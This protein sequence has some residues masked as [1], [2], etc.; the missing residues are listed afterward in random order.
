MR[1]KEIIKIVTT[2][3][4]S[5]KRP[6]LDQSTDFPVAPTEDIPT[7]LFPTNSNKQE[8]DK[9]LREIV[10]SI[11]HHTEYRQVAGLILPDTSI[12][13]PQTVVCSANVPEKVVQFLTNNSFSIKRLK[14]IIEKGVCI[15]IEELGFASYYPNTHHRYLKELSNIFQIFEINTLKEL[16]SESCWQEGDGLVTPIMN[17]KGQLFGLILLGCP[18]NC[19]V[20]SINAILP[21]LAFASQLAQAVEHRRNDATLFKINC[22]LNREK[23]K[24]KTLFDISAQ[25]KEASKLDQKLELMLKGISDIGWQRASIYLYDEL[26]GLERTLHNENALRHGG[27]LSD[28]MTAERRSEIF[29]ILSD[30]WKVEQCYYLRYLDTEAQPIIE[31]F[32]EGTWLMTSSAEAKEPNR[33]HPY[34][35]LL[36]PLRARGGRLI[37]LIHV[38]DPVDGRRPSIED[39][40]ILQLYGHESALM[41]EQASLYEE[42]AR[43]YER[44]QQHIIELKDTN[45]KLQQLEHIRQEFTAA[46]VHDIRSPMTVVSGTLELM[47]IQSQN[48]KTP[49]AKFSNTLMTLIENAFMTSK[50]IVS[51]VNELLDLSK[52]QHSGLK[53]NKTLIKP[54][55]IVTQ[56]AYECEAIGLAKKMRVDFGSTPNLT[57]I[58]ADH[59]YLQRALVN[60]LANAI[61]YT[62]NGGQIWFEA[63]LIESDTF[64]GEPLVVEGGKAVAFTI[65]DSGPGIPAEDV[66][67]LFDPYYQASNRKGQIGTGLGLAIVKRV[68]VAHGGNVFV[69]SQINV[70]SSFSLVIPVGNAED[71]MLT[72]NQEDASSKALVL[73]DASANKPNHHNGPDDDDEPIELTE[74]VELINFSE[75]A[76]D[77]PS[78]STTLSSSL[79]SSASSSA[80]SSLPRPKTPTPLPSP[81][82]PK[83]LTE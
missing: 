58:F 17:R 57:P 65:I 38:A 8:L 6:S 50:Q 64:N 48:K 49:D 62:P 63:R 1:R 71:A 55:D 83:E 23:E 72:V 66:P 43:L 53:L 25:V 12:S 9:L 45:V 47:L 77:M 82:K 4:E 44:E 81:S 56:V 37:G 40:T 42:K 29:H 19:Q 30:R 2:P 67:H 24:L 34:D 59:S 28:H 73:A 22:E 78:L 61:K 52:I 10:D 70:G 41:V 5:R 20:P 46:L 18:K 74:G 16:S 32:F 79:S 35:L 75:S 54:E 3:L 26:L 11:A 68:A 33:W 60:L 15:L 7:L 69:N 39:C 76:D 14:K 80:V 51:M 13:L 21:I 36:V 31:E 27:L